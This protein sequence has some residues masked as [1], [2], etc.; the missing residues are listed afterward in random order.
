[1]AESIGD[2][3]VNFFFKTDDGSAKKADDA[4]KTLKTRYEGLTDSAF[5]FNQITQAFGAILAPLK[6]AVSSIAA[7]GEEADKMNDF[8]ESIGTSVE[9]LERM[10]YVG[11]LAGT[12]AEGVA[13]GMKMLARE[14]HGAADGKDESVKVF[15]ELGV[16]FKDA[17]GKMREVGQV[18]PE[19][20]AKIAALPTDGQ[21]AKA[22][23]DAFGKAGLELLPM[24]KKS[25]AELVAL[26]VE[27]DALGGG[28]NEEFVKTSAAF[29]DNMDRTHRILSNMR[30]EIA[31]G[32]LPV[33]NRLLDRFVEWGKSNWPIIKDALNSFGQTLGKVFEETAGNAFDTFLTGAADIL[34]DQERWEQLKQ[35]LAGVGLALAGW[36]ALKNPME[37]LFT[38]L[39]GYLEDLW[40][41]TQGKD[42][43]FGQMSLWM[44]DFVNSMLEAVPWLKKIVD[45]VEYL[46]KLGGMDHTQARESGAGLAEFIAGKGVAAVADVLPFSDA[47]NQQL[48][49]EK[50]KVLESLSP[51]QGKR[52]LDLGLLGA[53]TQADV[54]SIAKVAANVT[55]NIQASPGMD[56]R[57]LAKHIDERLNN[58]MQNVVNDVHDSLATEAP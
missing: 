53:K 4:L 39:L 14:L 41:M 15:K 54:N 51:K 1:M 34:K 29:G 3:F 47:A 56:T 13:Q 31:S 25:Q 38:L 57:Q 6:S 40:G 7:V 17:G 45:Y 2:F 42:S 33:F 37:V 30:R 32:I 28:F 55:M 5:K 11:E 43:V 49:I 58:H 10:Q 46:R 52:A 16:S 35:V 36:I 50:R 44:R 23:M 21:K 26:G 9:A 20:I 48:D 24:L 19:V 27:F 22:A 18:M 8:A 12:S